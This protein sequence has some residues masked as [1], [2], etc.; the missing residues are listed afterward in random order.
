M[1]G[2]RQQFAAADLQRGLEEF[3]TLR[4]HAASASARAVQSAQSRLAGLVR[5]IEGEIIPRLLLVHRATAPEH[6]DRPGVAPEDVA[7]F[8]RLVL[9]HPLDVAMSFVAALRAQQVSLDAIYLELVGASARH[10]GVLW[11]DDDIDFTQVTLGLWRLQQVLHGLRSDFLNEIPAAELGGRVLLAPTPGEQH[12][13]GLFIVG[14]FLRRDGWS[15]HDES[16]PTT[17][18]L[19]RRVSAEWFDVIGLSLSCDTKFDALVAAIRA[20][21]RAS[22]N[23][24]IGVMVGGRLFVERPEMVPLSGADVSSVDARDATTQVRNLLSLLAGR[25]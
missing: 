2:M 9:S 17:E 12:G 4:G 21:R 19:A 15:V 18:G 16:G 3:S 13:F 24:A 23:R 22:C 1:D 6:A 5:T 11:E 25:R 20:I 10:L 14:E 7:E 8:S